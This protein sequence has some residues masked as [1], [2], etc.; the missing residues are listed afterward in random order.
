MVVYVCNY[1]NKS[2][3]HTIMELN[4]LHKS[5]NSI[6]FWIDDSMLCI[7]GELKNILFY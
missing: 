1:E 4:E 2:L 7:G 6:A 5:I 3:L